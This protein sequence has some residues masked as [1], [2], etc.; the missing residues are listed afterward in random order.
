MCA[1]AQASDG[2]RPGDAHPG[3]ALGGP[4]AAATISEPPGRVGVPLRRGGRASRAV[5]GQC[6][7]CDRTATSRFPSAA[8]EHPVP[9]H[10]SWCSQ[11]RLPDP[12]GPCAPDRVDPR[13]RRPAPPGASQQEHHVP[14]QLHRPSRPGR[15]VPA[16]ERARRLWRLLRRRPPRSPA[17]HD[18]VAKGLDLALQ[19]GAPR[20][21]RRRGEHRRRRRHPDP[22]PRRVPA[23]R[24]ADFELPPAG[25]LRRGHGL[26]ARRCRGGRRRGRRDRQDLRRGG[27]RGPGLAR[28]ADRLLHDRR[29]RGGGHADVPPAV[30]GR[31]RRRAQPASSW[32]AVA[33]VVRKRIEHEI[34]D[35]DG[36]PA[37]TSRRCRPAPWSTRGC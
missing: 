3:T 13:T 37:S 35:A 19:P 20:R 8:S 32:T 31:R 12:P 17:S 22:G 6:R 27:P 5:Q 14:Q 10:R 36:E 33:Y 26:P 24:G 15:P 4:R 18:L 29:H 25:Q 2:P 11:R 28:R 7:R 16:R 23:G 1:P 9:E 21:H 30:P 34:L